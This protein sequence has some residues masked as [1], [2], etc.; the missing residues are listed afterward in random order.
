MWSKARAIQYF[1][2]DCDHDQLYLLRV[3]T[4]GFDASVLLNTYL[5]VVENRHNYSMLLG[6]AALVTTRIVILIPS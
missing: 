4:L 5:S 6:C 2:L 3:I 1:P